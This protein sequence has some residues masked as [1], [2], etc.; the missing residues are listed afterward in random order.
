MERRYL[1]AYAANDFSTALTAAEQMEAYLAPYP[2]GTR[3][4]DAV[5]YAGNALY[6]PDRKEENVLAETDSQTWCVVEL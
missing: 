4:A 1:N 2:D 3:Y 6:S 5:N